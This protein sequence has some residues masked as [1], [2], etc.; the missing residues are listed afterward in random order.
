MQNRNVLLIGGG[1]SVHVM[2]GM[3][4]H[5]G[6]KVRV[7]STFESEASQMKA[8]CDITGGIQVTSECGKEFFG[9]PVKISKHPEDVVPG[10]DLIILS[11]PSFLHE[12]YLYCIEPYVCAGM[13]IGAFPAEGTPTYF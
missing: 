7:L 1:N 3:F 11:L 13:T 5:M 6:A 10:C 12:P 4:S 2:I 9:T 8:A